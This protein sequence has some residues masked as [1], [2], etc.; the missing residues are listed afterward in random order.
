VGKGL[1]AFNYKDFA[2]YLQKKDDRDKKTKEIIMTLHKDCKTFIESIHF[3]QKVFRGSKKRANPLLKVTP[4]KDRKPKDMPQDVHA[5]LGRA[6][7][8]RFGWNPRTEG[9]FATGGY[10]QAEEYGTA[11]YFFPIGDFKVV[12]SKTVDDLLIYLENQGVIQQGLIGRKFELSKRDKD[13][14]LDKMANNLVKMYVQD[15]NTAKKAQY[16]YNEM[17]FQCKAYYLVDTKFV[18]RNY[19]EVFA[20]AGESPWTDEW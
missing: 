14:D 5:A 20:I 12:Y 9:V 8:K 15:T 1:M 7:V 4:R 11:Y 13:R 2:D 6:F 16:S 10:P 17:M 3:G 18:T 19:D